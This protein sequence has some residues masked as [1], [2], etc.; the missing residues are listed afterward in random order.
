MSIPSFLHLEGFSEHWVSLPQSLLIGDSEF[1]ICS[2]TFL[3]LYG[4]GKSHICVCICFGICVHIYLC[5]WDM[6]YENFVMMFLEFGVVD[7]LPVWF[8]LYFSYQFVSCVE[9]CFV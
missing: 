6:V 7:L 8:L 9:F 5:A 4:G 3:Y 2:K 1:D